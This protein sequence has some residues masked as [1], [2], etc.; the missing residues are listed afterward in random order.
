MLTHRQQAGRLASNAKQR[1]ARYDLKTILWLHEELYGDVLSAYDA[2][3]VP[4]PIR[5]ASS[6]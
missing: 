6:V 4:D 5:L 3:R 1:I 2:N